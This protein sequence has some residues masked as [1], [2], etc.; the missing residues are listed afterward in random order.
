M[1]FILVGAYYCDQVSA[2]HVRQ[3]MRPCRLASTPECLPACLPVSQVIDKT[4]NAIWESRNRGV[5][6][7]T[8]QH[9]SLS[10]CHAASLTL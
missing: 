2:Q 4:V 1:P 3:L 9:N 10:E 6:A 5:S 8:N 7:L